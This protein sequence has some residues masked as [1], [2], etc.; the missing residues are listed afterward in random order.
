MLNEVL[1]V[2]EKNDIFWLKANI[3]QQKIKDL[4]TVYYKF[5]K[6]VPSKLQKQCKKDNYLSV[7]FGWYSIHLDIVC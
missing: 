6:E 1:K 5:S 2:C 7:D 3:K 4:V